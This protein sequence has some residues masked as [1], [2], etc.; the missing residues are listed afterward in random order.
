MLRI[1]TGARAC[2]LSGTGHV[3]PVVFA[4]SSTFVPEGRKATGAASPVRPRVKGTI[5]G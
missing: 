2:C 4:K 3:E 1:T 5:D